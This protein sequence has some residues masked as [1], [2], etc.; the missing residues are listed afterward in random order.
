[1]TPEHLRLNRGWATAVSALH[2][3]VLTWILKSRT[4]CTIITGVAFLQLSLSASGLSAWRSP[5]HSTFGVPDFGCG[6]TRAVLAL[7]RGDLQTAL[8]LHAFAP[9]IVAALILIA[10]A[11]IIP[12]KLRD[13]TVA[14]V[15]TIERRTGLTA[16]LLIGLVLYWLARLLIM[17]E[18]FIL[19]VS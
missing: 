19:L 10:L 5:L 8:I 2:E 9:L 11:A 1:M 16:I 14:W 15:E 3:P 18:A 4:T 12:S 6:L 7:L 13:E 17:R